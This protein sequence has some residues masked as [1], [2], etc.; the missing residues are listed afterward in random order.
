VDYENLKK[1]KKGEKKG[2]KERGGAV[3]FYIQYSVLK[4]ATGGVGGRE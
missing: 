2:K 3:K 4:T 1:R